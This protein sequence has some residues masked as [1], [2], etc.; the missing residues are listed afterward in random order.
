MSQL[1]QK[2]INS[3]AVRFKEKEY[4]ELKY[5]RIVAK[6]F[7][8]NHHEAILKP[9]SFSLLPKL[10]KS[11]E[12][13]YGDPSALPTYLISQLASK[14]LKVVLNGDGGDDI[15]AGYQRYHKF[16]ALNL[17]S[18]LIPQTA[19]PLIKM[20]L[21]LPGLIGKK[22]QTLIDLID[23]PGFG[24][25]ASTYLG[26][27]SPLSFKQGLYKKEFLSAVDPLSSQKLILKQEKS[28]LTELD[29]VLLADI[30]IYLAQVLLPKVDIASMSQGLEMRSPFLDHKLVELACK[31]PS[32]LKL[33]K[34]EGK[35]ILKKSLKGILPDEILYR[36]KMGFGFPLGTW[37]RNQ[38]KKDI[39]QTLLSKK[40]MI[41]DYLNQEMIRQMIDSPFEGEHYDRRLWRV[42]MLELWLQGYFGK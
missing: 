16:G 30:N 36:K 31:I 8:T 22:T 1:S 39:S 18:R 42:L 13:P 14:K 26:L 34:K 32:R 12:E 27:N 40:A 17:I 3:F 38:W 21:K 20:G 35:Y 11:Y 6:K 24:Q 29:N 9:Q 28:K 37:I 23:Q 41:N 4:S 19:K 5:A 2:K 33:K 10:A 7:K 15:F 25:Y